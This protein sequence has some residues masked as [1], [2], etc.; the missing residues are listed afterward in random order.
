MH[1]KTAKR[2]EQISR[3]ILAVVTD[4]AREAALIPQDRR[5]TPDDLRA[6]CALGLEE[7]FA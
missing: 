2:A 1:V 3:E 7:I 4:D 5:L 6:A